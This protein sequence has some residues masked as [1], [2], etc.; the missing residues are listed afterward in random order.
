PAS[1][2]VVAKVGG[3]AVA[4]DDTETGYLAVEDGEIVAKSP[5]VPTAAQVP[6]DPTGTGL[7]ATDVQGAI[8]EASG[9]LAAVEIPLPA[10]GFTD[11]TVYTAPTSKLVE[12]FAVK[13]LLVEPMTGA[14][15]V[16]LTMGATA[17][18]DGYVIAQPI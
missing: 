16:T 18:G 17:G 9:I 15:T 13:A 2:T 6:F 1:A 14:G 11:T 12:I 10:S 3:A 4:F 7:S 5:P 8:V